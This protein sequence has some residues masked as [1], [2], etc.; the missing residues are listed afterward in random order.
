M[1]NMVNMTDI[2]RELVCG[3]LSEHIY[4]LELLI[5]NCKR[6]G[7]PIEKNKVRLK[8]LKTLYQKIRLEDK[9]N[10]I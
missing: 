7:I 3:I 9:Y 5:S 1:K 10:V 8:E 4:D 2:E 6:N